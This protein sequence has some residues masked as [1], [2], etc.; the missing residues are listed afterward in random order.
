MRPLVEWAQD[1]ISRTAGQFRFQHVDVYNQHYNPTGTIRGTEF[2]FPYPDES[3]DLILLTSVFTHMLPDEVH[4]YLDE[5]RRVLKPGGRCFTTC[6]LLNEESRA[7]IAEGKSSQKLIHRLK[8]CY[9]TTPD[10]PEDSIGYDEQLLLGWIAERG[11]TLQGKRYG[12]WCDRPRFTS[13]QDV[14]VYRKPLEATMRM[15]G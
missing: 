14:L 11:F 2:R 12:C 13:Y 6:F 7:L 3:F 9:T 8:E 4:H 15:A 5:F 1:A 10:D